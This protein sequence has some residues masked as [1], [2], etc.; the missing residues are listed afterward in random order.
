MYRIYAES[1]L[2]DAHLGQIL[3]E[4]EVIVGATLKMAETTTAGSAWPVTLEPVDSAAVA[5]W[6]NEG[7]PN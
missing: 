6:R 5:V 1:F 7:D 3:E 2:G 4:A